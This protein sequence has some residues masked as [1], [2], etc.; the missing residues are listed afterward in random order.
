MTDW[1]EWHAEYQDPDSRLSLRRREVQTQ[2]AAALDRAPAG[3]LRLISACAGE[4]LDVIPVLDAHDRG[5]D[6][7]ARLVEFDPQLA[8]A[9]RANSGPNVEVITGDASITDAYFEAVPANIALFCGV[10]G[11]ITDEDVKHTVD[12]LPSLLAP[13]G[14]VIW[15]RHTGAPDLTPAIRAWFTG[16]GFEEMDFVAS[17]TRFAVGTHRLTTTPASFEAGVTLF[18]FVR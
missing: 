9:A 7:T 16:A 6:V 17:E 2:L 4:G 5:V 14:E 11:N 1:V 12:T 8:D 3:K 10:F 18:T 15:T 13:G